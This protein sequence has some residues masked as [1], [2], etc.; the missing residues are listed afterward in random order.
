M[1]EADDHFSTKYG[2][3]DILGTP[4]GTRGYDDLIESAQEFDLDG[5]IV[6][7]VSLNDLVAMKLAAGRPK[8][9][10]AVEI[11]VA[12]REEIEGTQVDALICERGIDRASMCRA[13]K[14]ES[15]VAD[16]RHL[17]YGQQLLEGGVSGVT[18]DVPRI[19]AERRR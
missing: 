19:V 15:S 13:T 12:L 3:F 17:A 8:D 14:G 11:L 1:D 7:L 5:L 2:D 6:A 18:P 9:R 4:S 16:R 10:A